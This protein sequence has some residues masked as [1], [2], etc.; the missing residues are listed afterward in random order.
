M[1]QIFLAY[2]REDVAIAQSLKENLE[3]KGYSVFLDVG[4]HIEGEWRPFL[5]RMIQECN[6]IVVLVSK[7]TAISHEV[8]HEVNVAIVNRKNVIPTLLQ[9]DLPTPPEWMQK[10]LARQA[11]RYDP[12]DLRVST[13]RIVAHLKSRPSPFRI[14]N[15]T[16]WIGLAA[17][18]AL[19]FAIYIAFGTSLLWTK[20][21]TAQAA[22]RGSAI[23]YDGFRAYG[24][25]GFRFA[26]RELVGW[27]SREADLL[28]AKPEGQST[29][30]LFLP[31]DAESYKN[32]SLDSNARAGIQEIS[33]STLD[34]IGS[35]P[36]DG[37]LHHWYK[38]KPGRLYCVRW[39][40]GIGYSAI[41]VDT[42]DSDRIGFDYVILQS[43]NSPGQR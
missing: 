38:P 1:A 10:V 35:C 23:V 18:L 8:A 12:F 21:K 14:H 39:R 40:D 42:I 5:E 36:S 34:S 29:T 43:S 33:G 28:A 15:N 11:V 17:T 25:S 3:R 32:P 16:F 37:Y 31:Y 41:R 4:D 6:D 22:V 27:D 2:A 7:G 30:H 13:S 19:A 24:K 26:S 9:E 20:G